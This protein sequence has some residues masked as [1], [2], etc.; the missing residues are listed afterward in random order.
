MALVDYSDSESDSEA[1]AQPQPKP[2]AVAP[3]T[4]TAKKPVQ[5]VVDRSNPRK[6]VVNL[7]GASGRDEAQGA[8]DKSDEPPAKRARTGGGAFGGFASLLPPP[9]NT[10]PKQPISS[11]STSAAEAAG[12]SGAAAKPPP[13]VGI[14]LKTGATPGFSRGADFD[15]DED[16]GKQPSIPEGQKPAEEVK[17][18]G[19]PLMFKPLSVSRKPKKNGGRPAGSMAPKA[20]SSAAASA[21]TTEA[22][23]PAA[24]AVSEAEQPKKKKVSL[25][26]IAAEADE[27]PEPTASGGDYEP[28]FA[29]AAPSAA[30]DFAAYDAQYGSAFAQPQEHPG[31]AMAAPQPSSDIES[32]ATDLNLSAAERRALFGRGGAPT[33]AQ[34]AGSRVI[35][36]NTDREY[37]H[38]EALRASGELE[39]QQHNPVRAIA[40]GK[41]SLRQLVTQVHNQRDALEESFAKGHSNRNEAGAR[42]GWR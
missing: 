17:L 22:Q 31:A 18:V 41:H 25:F 20:A 3:A 8:A 1:V 11:S 16:G 35:T 26:S 14:N 13:R 30:D 40:P 6:I 7:S 29:S 21:A 24:V 23:R 9:K 32:M 39:A 19:K 36:F 37:A 33:A 34:A 42:Y 10:K 38:N 15:F 28:M 4:T 5:K 27:D 2:A 12:S